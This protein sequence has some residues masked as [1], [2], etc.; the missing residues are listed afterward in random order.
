MLFIW[1]MTTNYIWQVVTVGGQF[2]FIPIMSLKR[3]FLGSRK[4]AYW[5]WD[6]GGNDVTNDSERYQ[7]LTNPTKVEGKAWYNLIYTKRRLEL[8]FV[9]F[10]ESSSSL[11]VSRVPLFLWPVLYIF[12]C[13][14][15]TFI[16]C[17]IPLSTK[18]CKIT[19]QPTVPPLTLRIR[20][21]RTVYSREERE[22]SARWNSS[23]QARLWILLVITVNKD[24]AALSEIRVSR[25]LLHHC[26]PWI[27]S[28]QSMKA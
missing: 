25:A 23:E 7:T 24:M 11:L 13:K 16:G 28:G 10:I 6:P 1:R 22:M 9:I 2:A 8:L 18:Q 12:T 17:N 26:Y 4:N 14:W 3:S 5:I 27:P 21:D 15:V 20:M 19:K